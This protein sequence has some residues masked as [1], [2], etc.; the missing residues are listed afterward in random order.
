MLSR[1]EMEAIIAGGG[2][3][4]HGGRIITRVADLPSELDLAAGDPER[5]AAAAAELE[6]RIAALEAQLARV[7][8]APS[9]PAK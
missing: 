9:K 7:R 4:L 1:S 8:P 3:V 2:S 6:Q 5:E